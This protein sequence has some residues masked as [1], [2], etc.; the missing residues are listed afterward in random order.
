MG[1][2]M[3]TS[4]NLS[5]LLPFDLQFA[6]PRSI[7]GIRRQLAPPLIHRLMYQ[8]AQTIKTRSFMYQVAVSTIQQCYMTCGDEGP[9]V[10]PSMRQ[11]TTSTKI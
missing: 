2:P 1:E 3:P 5:L 9:H 8:A 11:Q 10:H 4:S 7:H 6:D